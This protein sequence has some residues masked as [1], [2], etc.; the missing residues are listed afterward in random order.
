M[1]KTA[2]I[3]SNVVKTV[4]KTRKV[5]P[6]AKNVGK[7]NQPIP[8]VPFLVKTALKASISIEKCF[9]FL[10]YAINTSNR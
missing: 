3:V 2:L 7:E 9:A 10:L 4:T 5:R 1:T 8:L 6:A